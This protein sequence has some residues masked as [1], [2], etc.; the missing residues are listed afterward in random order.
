MKIIVSAGGT[1]GH[2]YPA[3]A[4]IDKFKEKE[5]KIDVLYIGTHNRMEKDIVPS[6]G[7]KYVGLEIYGLSKTNLK[8]DIKNIFLIKK[9]KRKCLEIMEDF[10]PDVVIGVGGYVTYP[11]IWAAK[12]LGIKTF[13]HEQNSIPG[14]TNRLIANGASLVG[15][16]FKN[17]MSYFSNAKKV[18]YTGNPCGSNA[19]KLPSIKPSLYGCKEN[20]KTILMVAGSLGS[21]TLNNKMRVFLTLVGDEDYEYIYVTGKN[22][23]DEFVHDAKFPKNVHVVPFIDSLAG[24]I[25]NVD[26]VISRAG[27]ST[28]SEILAL[29]VPSI[30]IPS[31]YVAN[32]HQ[33]YN[34]LD[35]ENLGVSILIEEK[36]LSP[37]L[38]LVTINDLMKNKYTKM[39]KNLDKLNN[40]S[41]SEI[42]YEEI[43][44][45]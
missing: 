30:L 15:V 20:R 24:L 1:G 29:K 31:P 42:I 22:Y 37:E 6:K 16:S 23:Y 10:K 3:L 35:L 36:K 7:I 19:L 12:K 28:L 2:I 4:I 44:K 33:Y 21:E 25:R 45:L 5:S 34:A 9:A 8:R 40:I 26:L 32:N 13:I 41:S 39:K 17:S 14:K 11:V 38:L 18:V 27:A 43:K